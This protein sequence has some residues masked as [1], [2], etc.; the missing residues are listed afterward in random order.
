[1]A[2]TDKDVVRTSNE[3][4][5]SF[6]M[7]VCTGQMRSGDTG[8]TYTHTISDGVESA[9]LRDTCRPHNAGRGSDVSISLHRNTW[10]EVL[11]PRSNPGD[12]LSLSTTTIGDSLW[13][14]RQSVFQ[15][16]SALATTIPVCT[17]MRAQ[18]DDDDVPMTMRGMYICQQSTSNTHS[19]TAIHS[20]VASTHNFSSPVCI[21][22]HTLICLCTPPRENANEHT[23]RE[24]HT[25]A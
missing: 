1:M 14:K 20:T 7:H 3:K 5:S 6:R 18:R 9:R 23:Q 10:A 16:M 17:W 19:R 24:T 13:E 22:S 2:H 4:S 11:V 12:M 25:C 15:M 8:D 21:Y